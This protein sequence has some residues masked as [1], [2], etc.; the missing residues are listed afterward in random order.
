MPSGEERVLTLHKG[1]FEKS[2][3]YKVKK[4]WKILFKF[5]PEFLADDDLSLYI[6]YPENGAQFERKKYQNIYS[7]EESCVQV[8]RA[9]SY[10]YYVTISEEIVCDGYI[11]VDPDLPHGLQLDSVVC[12]TVLSKLL[13][14]LHT[15]KDKLEVAYRYRNRISSVNR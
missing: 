1:R 13:G 10:H 2:T 15:W 6:N 5:S 12:Q 14:P 11:S 9:G 7:K 4:G 3:L 8:T